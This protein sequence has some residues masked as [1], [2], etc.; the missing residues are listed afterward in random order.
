MG[1]GFRFANL[2]LKVYGHDEMHTLERV[3]GFTRVL[4][5][6]SDE[7]VNALTSGLER[8]REDFARLAAAHP[9]QQ[10]EAA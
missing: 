10:K 6:W 7:D 9:S 5:G 8:L 3:A 1:V 4:E 2:D